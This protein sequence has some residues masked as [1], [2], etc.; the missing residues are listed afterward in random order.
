LSVHELLEAWIL[1]IQLFHCSL[2][3]PPTSFKRLVI[4][5]LCL[6]VVR[7]NPPSYSKHRFEAPLTQRLLHILLESLPDCCPC[8]LLP[9]LEDLPGRRAGNWLKRLNPPPEG[10]R[11]CL[12]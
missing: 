6:Q 9:W 5:T 3:L 8:L 1:G 10:R 12:I 4:H 7:N 2:A 11:D